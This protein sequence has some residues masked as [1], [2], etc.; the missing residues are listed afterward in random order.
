MIRMGESFFIVAEVTAEGGEL[1][2]VGD[3]LVHCHPV[4]AKPRPEWAPFRHLDALAQE[5]GVPPLSEFISE[6]PMTAGWRF[7]G[8]VRAEPT[9]TPRWFTAA[10]GIATVRGLLDY[11]TTHTE[12]VADVRRVI[13]GL[14]ECEEVVRHLGNKGV[15]W[16]LED[17]SWW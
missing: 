17:G 10:E 7:F 13:A 12:K 11:L 9:T 14:R 1:F 2:F 15:L 5:A 16:H 8:D 3:A 6:D 4:G